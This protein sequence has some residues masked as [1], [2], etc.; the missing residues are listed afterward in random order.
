MRVYY[1]SF[2]CICSNVVILFSM[3]FFVIGAVKHLAIFIIALIFIV[4]IAGIAYII[5]HMIVYRHPRVFFLGHTEDYEGFLKEYLTDLYTSIIQCAKGKTLLG[6]KPPQQLQ[7]LCQRFLDTNSVV[8]PKARLYGGMI[9]ENDATVMIDS[10][11]PEKMPALYM[12]F[13]FG[14][15]IKNLES[16]NELI[17]YSKFFGNSKYG[18]GLD[19]PNKST[20]EAKRKLVVQDIVAIDKFM[21]ALH[22]LGLSHESNIV[23]QK[24]ALLASYRND[25]FKAFDFR[26]SGGAGN[27]KLFKLMMREYVDYVWVDVLPAKWKTI[28][29]DIKDTANVFIGFITSKKVA[30]YMS[31]LPGRIAG[32]ENF[33]APH[34]EVGDTVEHFGFLKALMIIP[35]F[36]QTIFV[37][38]KALAAAFTNPILAVRIVV[39]LV[40]GTFL[41]VLYIVVSTMS[42][43]FYGLAAI[44]I[45]IL[46]IVQSAW[47]VILFAI[48]SIIYIVLWLLDYASGG[49][50]LP[51]FRCENLPSS[52]F[53]Q[54]AYW[55]GNR[56][57]R[58][59]FCS[60]PCS[61]K[62]KPSAN[63]G[64]WCD[65]QS[66]HSASF[67]PQQIIYQLYE[68]IL[69]DTKTPVTA[70]RAIK[71]L[72]E[73]VITPR[74]LAQG[75]EQKKNEILQ[76]L[77]AK[78]SFMGDCE[79]SIRD[80]KRVYKFT[81]LDNINERKKNQPPNN[82]YSKVTLSICTELKRILD[83][84]TSLNERQ[85]KLVKQLQV[86]CHETY[87]KYSYS[88]HRG[89][90]K[91]KMNFPNGKT[92][93]QFCPCLQTNVESTIPDM[94][95]ATNDT[96]LA[97]QFFKCVLCILIVIGLGTIIYNYSRDDAIS[98]VK[99]LQM[100]ILKL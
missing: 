62:F 90:T 33:L 66:I 61:L 89:R 13:I 63:Q 5:Y 19:S 96:N 29:Q 3:P 79:G 92:D 4:A 67:C 49:V 21:D 16:S 77:E 9:V 12:Y 38:A 60:V 56:Y 80:Y 26:K 35:K 58:G 28:G 98:F 36:F 42:F 8:D 65:R 86:M 11:T 75:E 97:L 40:L 14:E 10:C 34:T 1:N 100:Q 27:M 43:L 74:F 94:L 44:Y 82:V 20:L 30:L 87:C 24:L 2:F 47:W 85:S 99:I 50:I 81:Y 68:A 45:L 93:Y 53:N 52:W 91:A 76:F 72:P 17:L 69:D 78:M 70:E 83:D 22:T 41:Y 15:A 55:L 95:E 57:K 7:S 51:L 39:G 31:T 6:L 23:V 84:K 32:L 48:V 37:L 71:L 54:S 88:T 73:F 46:K 18:Q 59:F 25:I 64:S